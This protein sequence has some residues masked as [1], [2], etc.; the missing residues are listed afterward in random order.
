MTAVIMTAESQL[1]IL[2][3]ITNALGLRKRAMVE[4]NDGIAL[5]LLETKERQ[6]R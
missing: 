1:T 4:G 2:K 5:I 3:N 6:K